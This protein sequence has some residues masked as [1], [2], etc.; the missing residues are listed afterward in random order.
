MRFVFNVSGLTA[1]AFFL[2]VDFKT[3]VVSGCDAYNDAKVEDQ[4]GM[5][6]L[7]KIG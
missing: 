1:I 3:N 6:W 5:E 7:W 2:N 4:Y